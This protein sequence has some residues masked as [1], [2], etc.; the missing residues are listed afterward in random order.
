MK[1]LGSRYESCRRC[2]RLA[3]AQL[4]GRLSL[5][6]DA[7]RYAERSNST[8]SMKKNGHV[9][10][11]K[12]RRAI[13]GHE[14]ASDRWALFG[15]VRNINSPLV[16]SLKCCRTTSGSVDHSPFIV[17]RRNSQEDAKKVEEH[18]KRNGRRCACLEMKFHRKD[19]DAFL[20]FVLKLPTPV[21]S[22]GEWRWWSGG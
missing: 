18:G 7:G 21:S 17:P 10:T 4:F 9:R 13:F 1:P 3:A 14:Q 8:G 22:T 19:G 6:L 2:F 11:R 16:D 12:T 20:S 15:K 5:A